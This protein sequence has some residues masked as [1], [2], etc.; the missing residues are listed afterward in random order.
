M[1]PDPVNPTH[2]KLRLRHHRTVVID[3]E[4]IVLEKRRARDFPGR[5][6]GVRGDK[7][8]YAERC[9]SK[10]HIASDV[11]AE[12]LEA[13][14]AKVQGPYSSLADAALFMRRSLGAA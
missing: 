12:N 5:W 1:S 3:G 2:S 11:D 4:A 7:E 14:E 9:G 6:Y 13:E 10:W 8:F